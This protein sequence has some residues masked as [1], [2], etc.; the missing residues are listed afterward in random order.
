MGFSVNFPGAG[1]GANNVA[2]IFVNPSYNGGA[3]FDNAVLELSN[4]IIGIRPAKIGLFNPLDDLATMLGYGL[5]GDGLGFALV[6]ANDRLAAQNIIDIYN[7]NGDLRTDFDSPA[8][9]TSTY[10]GIFPVTLEGTTAPGDSGGPIYVDGDIVGDLNGGFNLFGP[11]STYGDIS[12]WAPLA[13]PLTVAWLE[14]LH[15]PIEFVPEPGS[16]AVLLVGIVGLATL[17]ARRR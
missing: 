10:G 4:P 3:T 5:Q 12:I 11:A 13:N 7:I 1:L 17:V 14:S 6:G 9:T 15:Q 2:A 16:L 8:G